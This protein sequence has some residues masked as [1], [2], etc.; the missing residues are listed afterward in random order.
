MSILDWFNSEPV[1]KFRTD[2]AGS[3]QLSECRRCY[4]EEDHCGNSRRLKSNQ[5]SV[6]FTRT[7]FKDSFVQSPGFQHFL[8]SDQNQ[9]HTQT[10]PIDLHIDLGNFCNLA[11]KMCSPRASSTIASQQVKWGIESSKQYLGTN[12]TKNESVWNNFKQQLLEIPNLKNIHFM[13]GETLLTD[14]FEDLVDTMIKH[15]R[16]DLCFSFVSNGTVFCPELLNK[17]KQFC[18]VGIEISIETVDDH[19]AYQRQGTD[20]TQVLNNIQQYLDH[21]NNTSITVTLRP[22]VSILT[23]G[24]YDRLLQ[25]ALDHKLIVKGLLCYNPR[26]LNAE[27]LPT[28]IKQL[29]LERFQN[30]ITQLDDVNVN[31]DYNASDPNNYQ[32]AIKEQVNMCLN[33]LNTTTPVDSK[34]QLDLMVRHCERWDRVYRYNARQLYP[35]FLE[36]LIDNNYDISG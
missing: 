33:I 23:I 27:I 21:C 20:T 16:F 4:I 7:A 19:N 1:C 29:Y 12:W 35:E 25:Y 10:Q 26:F 28:T 32:K 34:E 36:I 18:R 15:K 22:A 14:R 2:I 9:G 30:L 11:C 17:L 24:Y 6:I 3:T 13:G 31:S 5:K 8:H